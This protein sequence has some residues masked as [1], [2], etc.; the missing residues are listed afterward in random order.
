[1][2][3]IELLQEEYAG[4]APRD[5]L[6]TNMKEKFD[7]GEEKVDSIIKNLKHK[8]RGGSQD[9]FPRQER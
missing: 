6:I 5:V 1:M 9:P 2:A 8:G 3:E 7:L 4:Q